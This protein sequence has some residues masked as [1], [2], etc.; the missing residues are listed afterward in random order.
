MVQEVADHKDGGKKC[1]KKPGHQEQAIAAK[2]TLA[3][4]RRE[5]RVDPIQEPHEHGAEGEIVRAVDHDIKPGVASDEGDGD[6]WPALRRRVVEA[7]GWLG[8]SAVAITANGDLAV[9]LGTAGF[10]AE[11]AAAT[12]E[13]DGWAK[14]TLRGLDQP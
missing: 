4:V 11:D 12:D 14:P 13:R 8:L 3:P 2:G 5:V 7:A 1:R 9:A 10:D 6:A